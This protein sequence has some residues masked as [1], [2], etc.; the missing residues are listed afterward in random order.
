MATPKFARAGRNSRWYVHPT[1]HERAWSVTTLLKALPKD[2]LT[3]WA[4]REAATYACDN[5][6]IVHA[7]MAKGEQGREE[8]IELV[9]KAPWRSSGKKADLG[10]L[11][12]EVV[13]ALILDAPL[14]HVPPEAEPYL[15]QFM[16]MVKEWEPTFLASEATVWNRTEKYAGSLDF[17]ATYPALGTLLVDV[18]TGKDAYPE[19]ALQ[20]AA[21]RAAEF[22]LADDGGEHP[23][24]PVDGGAALVLRPDR[25]DLIPVECGPDLFTAFLYVRE[26][27]RF[28]NETAKTVLGDPLRPVP[29]A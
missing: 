19:V 4:A 9:K 13:E 6:N 20:L 10:T 3:Y 22:I 8:A 1:T 18:K 17:I 26:V 27:Y 21:Y 11:I 29:S 28:T 16:L 25:Y 2:A 12:H 7:L 24:P 23:M 14:P 15:D 5:L